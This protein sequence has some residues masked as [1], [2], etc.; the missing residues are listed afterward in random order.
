MVMEY[1]S[2]SK[3]VVKF[4]LNHSHV[5]TM[6]RSQAKLN[7]LKITKIRFASHHIMLQRLLI[8]KD[9]LAITV[10]L[11][12]W[13][14]WLKR[15]DEKTKRMGG[16]VAETILDN[17]YW[18]DVRNIIKITEPLYKLI[19]F[20]D[21][22]DS[23]MGEM[24]EKINNMFGQIK[25]TMAGSKFEYKW[26]RMEAII[27]VRWEKIN[28]PIHVLAF[29]VTPHYYDPQYLA[30]LAPG[31]LPCKPPNQDIEVAKKVMI[32]FGKIAETAEKA[33]VYHEQ[34]AHF[35]MRKGMFAKEHVRLDS[36]HSY[37]VTWWSTYGAE[38]PELA[39]H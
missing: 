11:D 24:Y 14:E 17:E 15:G 22:E 38:T 6:F 28:I 13:T 32:V 33:R 3:N 8:C 23:K 39:D 2:T 27:L 12:K 4:F 26:D 9:E 5:L 7:L 20:A 35:H 34:F 18:D 37:V 1:I 19:R 29:A 30:M 25:E 36:Y 16:L 31:G 21:G 10:I